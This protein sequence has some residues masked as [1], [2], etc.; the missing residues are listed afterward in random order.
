M[1]SPLNYDS[2]WDYF[3]ACMTP[4]QRVMEDIEEG[5]PHADNY[6]QWARN[7][8]TEEIDDFL[9]NEESLIQRYAEMESQ[10]DDY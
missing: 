5:G 3:N 10:D 4:A 6:L 8:C 2:D 1:P 7:A 9:L